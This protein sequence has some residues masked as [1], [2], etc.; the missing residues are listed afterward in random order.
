MEQEPEL[1]LIALGHTHH[2]VLSEPFPGRWILNS[3]D[4]VYRRTY[5]VIEHGEGAPLAGLGRNERSDQVGGR[6]SSR[7]SGRVP[8]RIA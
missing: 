8:D 1:D 2:P 5:A 7:D 4:W 3:G 6:D